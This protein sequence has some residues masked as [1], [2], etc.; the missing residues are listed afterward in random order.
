MRLA[1][2]CITRPFS[3]CKSM[4]SAILNALLYPRCITVSY[5][6]D[7]DQHKSIVNATNTMTK[8]YLKSLVEPLQI[9]KQFFFLS[10]ENLSQ[11][12]TDNTG[13]EVLVALLCYLSEPLIPLHPHI[14][15]NIM[16]LHAKQ[17]P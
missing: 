15:K 12:P 14:R 11:P 3:P 1:N 9:S 8:I 6:R 5:L 16:M 17:N 13:L 4:C 2:S 10:S 7:L